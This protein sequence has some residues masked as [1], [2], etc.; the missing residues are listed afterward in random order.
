[1]FQRNYSLILFTA[2]LLLF[3]SFVFA[4]IVLPGQIPE[5]FNWWDVVVKVMANP[6]LLSPVTIGSLF[7]IACVQ[8]LK[9]DYFQKYFKNVSPKMQILIITTLG[10]IYSFIQSFL[11]GSINAQVILHGLIASGVAV[12]VF[13]LGKLFFEKK[14]TIEVK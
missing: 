4:Q 6:K 2:G 14:K 5:N 7:V 12:S 9:S 10:Q 13:N 1:M 8:F 11:T 3:A